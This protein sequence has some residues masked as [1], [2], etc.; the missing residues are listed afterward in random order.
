MTKTFQKI[1]FLKPQQHIWKTQE[2]DMFTVEK[3]LDMLLC[4]LGKKNFSKT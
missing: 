4:N 3:D 2:K 1:I